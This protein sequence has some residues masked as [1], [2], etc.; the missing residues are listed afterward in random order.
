MWKET[1]GVIGARKLFHRCERELCSAGVMACKETILKCQSAMEVQNC[2][3]TR[4][5]SELEVSHIYTTPSC[6]SQNKPAKTNGLAR[7]IH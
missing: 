2:S 6:G 7:P 4:G 5:A 3:W 1:E